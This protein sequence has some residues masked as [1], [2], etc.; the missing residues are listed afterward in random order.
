ML[1]EEERDLEA[2]M[3][4]VSVKTKSECEGGRIHMVDFLMFIIKFL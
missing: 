2:S 4:M 3:G 1:S